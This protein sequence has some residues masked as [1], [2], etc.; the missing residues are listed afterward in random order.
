MTNLFVKMRNCF[1]PCVSG[2]NGETVSISILKAEWN[3]R[4]LIYLFNPISFMDV[5]GISTGHMTI[6]TAKLHK[7]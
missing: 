7:K 3:S 5:A 1:I 6:T 4:L 2:V